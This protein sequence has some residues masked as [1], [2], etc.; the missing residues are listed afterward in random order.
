MKNRFYFTK[1]E[2]TVIQ[3]AGVLIVQLVKT[4]YNSLWNKVINR[5]HVRI[6]SYTLWKWNVIMYANVTL[7]LTLVS[8]KLNVQFFSVLFQWEKFRRALWKLVSEKG[9]KIQEKDAWLLCGR[10]SLSL[11][12]KPLPDFSFPNSRFS[13][14]K[15]VAF[16]KVRVFVSSRIRQY[17]MPSISQWLRIRCHLYVWY[18]YTLK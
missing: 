4:E 15:V 14:E 18:R 6:Y 2:C 16:V 3:N 5:Y 13:T 8:N 1:Y 12:A 9:A 7:P 11:S 10:V 17:D